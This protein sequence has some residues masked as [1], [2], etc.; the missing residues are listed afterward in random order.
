EVEPRRHDR[1][2]LALERAADRLD[3]RRVQEELPRPLGGV[4]ERRAGQLR[5][6]HA[7]EERLAALDRAPRVGQVGRAVA[8]G[9][10]LAAQQGQAG[11]VAIAQL[12][13]EARPLVA[14][15]E[16]LAFLRFFLLRAA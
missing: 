15:D 14:G 4:A 6:V 12:E 9:L 5:D 7:L 13:V 3:L 11:L 10:H 1:H 2:A 8:Q 16:L